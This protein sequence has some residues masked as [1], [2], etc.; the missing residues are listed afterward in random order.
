ML[1]NLDLYTAVRP[2]PRR[3]LVSGGGDTA[4]TRRSLLLSQQLRGVAAVRYDDQRR[5]AKSNGHRS[6]RGRGPGSHTATGG[7]H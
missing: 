2:V 3:H 4:T 7:N 5:Q 6:P 1:A